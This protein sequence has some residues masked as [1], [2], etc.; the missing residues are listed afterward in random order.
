MRTELNLR[1]GKGEASFLDIYLPDT[2]VFSVFVYF[3][4][5][6]L[7]KGDKSVGSVFADILTEKGIALVSA[8]YSMY[9]KAEY[10][11]FICDAAEAVAWVYNSIGKYGRCKKIYVGGSSAGA[12]LSMMLCF[13][14][15]YLGAYGIDPSALGGFLHD[16]GQPTAHF[17][18]LKERGTDPRRV[19]V[20]ESAP[21]YHICADK[22]YPPMLFVVSD[23]D[24]QGRFEQTMLVVSTLKHFGYSESKVFLKIM[25]GTHCHYV[26]K[27]D[28]NN[29]SIF[30]GMICDFI[31]S[32]EKMI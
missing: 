12:Y 16:A 19:I 13:C 21:L 7:E 4:G 5:G 1:Y 10:P 15:G 29:N 25:N 28:G 11:Q 17:R 27:L 31:D 23:N 6:G 26:R 18:V 9:P 24:M 32:A 20:D 14:N 30:A 22:N 3:H 2:D 8:N